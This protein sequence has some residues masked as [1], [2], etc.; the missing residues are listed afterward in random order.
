VVIFVIEL[1]TKTIQMQSMRFFALLWWEVWKQ[2][3]CC[4]LSSSKEG[5]GSQDGV[6]TMFMDFGSGLGGLW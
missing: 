4:F 1:W 5:Y 6:A 3:V 2:R